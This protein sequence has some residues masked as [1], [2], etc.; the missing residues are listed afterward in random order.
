MNQMFTGYPPWGYTL[1]EHLR[2]I[3]KNIRLYTNEHLTFHLGCDEPWKKINDRHKLW[4]KN[5]EL[6]KSV[7][8]RVIT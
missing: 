1:H 3:D 6:S 2:N 8:N 5:I 4:I 7:I